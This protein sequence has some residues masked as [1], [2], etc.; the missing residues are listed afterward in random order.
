MEPIPE[1]SRSQEAA[2]VLIWQVL[3]EVFQERAF[4]KSS[5]PSPILFSLTTV[6]WGV[7]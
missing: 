1:C 2:E 3:P 7:L 6:A 5:A 4:K